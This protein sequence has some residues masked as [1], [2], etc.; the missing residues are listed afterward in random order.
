[1]SASGGVQRSSVQGEHRAQ[2][3]AIG[4]RPRCK[5]RP[6]LGAVLQAAIRFG[7]TT[8]QR[9]KIEDEHENDDD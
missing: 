2:S 7:P 8:I 5:F 3:S 9:S 4:G 6:T 1:M